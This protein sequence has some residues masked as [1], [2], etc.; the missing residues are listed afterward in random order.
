MLR[1]GEENASPRHLE[2]VSMTC[3]EYNTALPVSSAVFKAKLWYF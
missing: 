3:S 1:I 2:T